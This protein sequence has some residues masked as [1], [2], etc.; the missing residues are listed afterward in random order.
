MVG[1][2]RRSYYLQNRHKPRRH[3]AKLLCSRRS[4]YKCSTWRKVHRWEICAPVSCYY[5]VPWIDHL[6]TDLLQSLMCSYQFCGLMCIL[7]PIYRVGY[8]AR[9]RGWWWTWGQ[10]GWEREKKEINRKM[11]TELFHD[12]LVRAPFSAFSVLQGT[13]H[14]FRLV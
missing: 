2:Y 13:F 11:I 3:R 12:L 5:P 1:V 8:C 14:P 10:R 6:E 7:D 4:W 9:W